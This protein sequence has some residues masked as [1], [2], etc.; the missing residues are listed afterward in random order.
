M[1]QRFKIYR[2]NEVIADLKNIK[3]LADFCTGGFKFGIYST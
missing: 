1:K 3:T 2:N